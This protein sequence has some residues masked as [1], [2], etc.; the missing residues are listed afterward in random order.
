MKQIV[1]AMTIL[2]ATLLSADIERGKKVYEAN[3][4]QCHS[5]RMTGGLGRDFNLVSYTRTKEEIVDY[6]ESPDRQYRKFGYNANA[7]PTLPLT[8]DEMDD[9]ADFIDSLQPFKKWM[10]KKGS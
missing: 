3:C 9:V 7:M 4:A 10:V 1:F 5:I 8:G 6:I 2:Y